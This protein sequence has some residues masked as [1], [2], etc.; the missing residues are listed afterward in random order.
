MASPRTTDK[1]LFFTHALIN[2]VTAV[3]EGLLVLRIALKLFGAST[4]APFTQW[5]Y[6][7]T[8]PLLSPFEGIFPTARL[9]GPFVIEFSALFALII[10]SFIGYLILQT[11]LT[12]EAR[13]TKT[14]R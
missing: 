6:E 10:Y 4:V 3:I 2:G 9:E 7:T 13:P 14:T 1:S 8:R 11:L 5:V 12:L